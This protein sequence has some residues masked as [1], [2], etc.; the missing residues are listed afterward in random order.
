MEKGP[1]AVR[2]GV[3]GFLQP[4]TVPPYMSGLARLPQPS[5]RHVNVF[6]QCLVHGTCLISTVGT[7]KK[8]NVFTSII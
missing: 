2:M 8:N 4:Q 7:T 3:L 6:V 5:V 1:E